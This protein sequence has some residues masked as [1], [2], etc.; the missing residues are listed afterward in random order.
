MT[1]RDVQLEQ[2]DTAYFTAYYNHTH[3]FTLF[4]CLAVLEQQTVC[5][6]A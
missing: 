3:R 1:A 2:K 4:V 5:H 6:P